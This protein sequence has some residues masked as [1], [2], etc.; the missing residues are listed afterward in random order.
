MDIS[1]GIAA[2]LSG[3]AVFLMLY[4][5]FAPKRFEKADIRDSAFNEEIASEPNAFDRY[6]RPALRNFLPQSPLGTN[7]NNEQRTKIQELLIRSGNPWKIRPEEFIG[8]Q[9]ML[10]FIGFIVGIVV[11]FFEL[12]PGVPPIAAIPVLALIGYLIPF[13]YHNTLKENRIKEIQKQL[14]EALDLLVITLS[15][16]QIFDS[17]LRSVVPRLPDGLLKKELEGTVLEI[18]A[19][20]NLAQSLTSFA[21]RVASDEA[22]SFAKAVVQAQ[23]LGADVSETLV[24]QAESARRNYEARLEKK[25]A[26]L[27]TT[28]FIPLIG[29]MLPAMLLIFTAPAL[30]QFGEM[31]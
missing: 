18:R 5:L 4:S 17:A 2:I 28:M 1:P 20:K 29:T 24:L 6:I 27:S 31:F 13:S 7:I 23:K 30:M 9:I 3:L 14:P 15:S 22:A 11:A 12:I 10:A 16:G 26:R 21:D 25:I 19:G 8:T